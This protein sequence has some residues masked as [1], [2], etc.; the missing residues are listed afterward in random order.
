MQA[1]ID[2]ESEQLHQLKLKNDELLHAKD[3]EIRCLNEGAQTL[4]G[5]LQEKESE[6]AQLEARCAAAEDR[7]Q[8]KNEE[9]GQRQVCVDS[10]SLAHAF[11][12]HVHRPKAAG[13]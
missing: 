12:H 3:D 1:R 8:Q 7:L 9:V 2:T 6:T 11:L 10:R 4:Q 13:G 5:K